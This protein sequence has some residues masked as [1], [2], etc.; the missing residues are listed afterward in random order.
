MDFSFAVHKNNL[1]N[2]HTK[3]VPGKGK[4]AYYMKP[5]ISFVGVLKTC[6]L[7]DLPWADAHIDPDHSI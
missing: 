3:W 2:L 7:S 1:K 4:L 6:I 5:F